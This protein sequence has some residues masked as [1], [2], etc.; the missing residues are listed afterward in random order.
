MQ[1]LMISSFYPPI[2]SGGYAQNCAEVTEG[3]RKRGHQVEVLTSR[4]RADSVASEKEVHRRLYLENNLMHYSPG[5]F[6]VRWIWEESQNHKAVRTLVQERQPDA[7]F[8]WSMYGLSRSVPATLERLMPEQVIYFISD[9]WPLEESLH[10]LYWKSPARSRRRRLAKAIM[11]LAAQKLLA[12]RNY[13]PKLEFKHAIVVSAVVQRN[14]IAADL[15]FASSRV[16]HSGRDPNQ[17]LFYRDHERVKEDNGRPLRLLYAGR[18][19]KHKGVHTAIQ[20]LALLSQEL[21]ERRAYLTIHGDGHPEYKQEL[22]R[23]ISRNALDDAIFL[24]GEVP[25]KCM[26]EVLR[27]HDVL[28]VP[29]ICEDA[30]PGVVLEAMLSG[31]AVIGSNRGGIPEMLL[32]ER[33]GLLC[34]ADAPEDLASQIGKLAADRPYTM[35]LAKQGQAR[36]LREF[37]SDRMVGNIEQYL[38][39]TLSTH[40]G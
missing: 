29:S 16:I 27:Q 9:H 13:P 12:L 14:L 17:F 31:L 23:L 28:L 19:G 35:R 5:H 22:V 8:I 1:I 6:F 11:R 2:G 18:L 7:V 15:P 34:E 30:L 37:T 24:A 4:C 21:Q 32:H 3:L 20:A 36:A 25:H 38:Q 39:Q 40:F 10:E 26:P 33:T